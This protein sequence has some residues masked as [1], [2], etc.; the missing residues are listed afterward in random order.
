MNACRKYITS[1]TGFAFLVVAGTGL[2]FKLFFKNHALEEIHGWVGILMLI[3][4]SLHLYQNWKS[5]TNHL[6]DFK[7]W[8]NLAPIAIIIALFSFGES[9]TNQIGPKQVMGNLFSSNIT[10][11]SQVFKKDPEAVLLN[12]KN[13][14]LTIDSSSQTLSKVAEDNKKKPQELLVYFK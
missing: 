9:E 3:F 7:T 12:M 14:G 4:A 11:V 8:L 10:V 2:F 13:S 6:K 5:F 1:G